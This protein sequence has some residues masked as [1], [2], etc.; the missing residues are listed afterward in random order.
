LNA[1][2]YR[3]AASF[4]AEGAIIEQGGEIRLR[5]RAA[6]I[7]FNRSLPCRATVT[8]VEDEKETVLATFRLRQGDGPEQVCGG[9]ARVRF[10]FKDGK[11]SE[12]RQLAET[13]SEGQ[14]A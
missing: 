9:I 5:D 12:W 13:M 8:E 14:P 10:K 6:A 2:D 3:R 4:F 11:F 1:G 7:A